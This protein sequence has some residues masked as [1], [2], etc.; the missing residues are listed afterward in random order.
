MDQFEMP[1][2]LRRRDADRLRCGLFE[3]VD[4]LSRLDGWSEAE[5]DIVIECVERQPAYA[6]RSDFAHFG[7]RLD[8]A[9]A[10]A[11]TGRK[12]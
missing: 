1:P 11:A 7:E 12:R 8:K 6:L 5:L 10:A 3:I 2:V 9:R 4:E